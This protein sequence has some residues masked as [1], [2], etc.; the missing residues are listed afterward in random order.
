MTDVL[1]M[2]AGAVGG[3]FG[4]CLARA[5]HH[6]TFVARGANL[7]AIRSAGLRVTGAMGDFTIEGANATDKPSGRADLVV[8]CVKNYDLED[9]SRAVND[10]GG[11]VVTTQNGVDA[12]GVVASIVGDR[13]LA[14]TTGIV[15]DL[16]EPGHVHCVSAYAWLRF[17]E[18]HGGGISDRVRMV[19]DVLSVEGIEPLPVEDARVALWEK[20]A[21]MC[22]MAGLTTLHQQPMGYILSDP[23]LRTQF[24]DVVRE[25][26]ALAR[27]QGVALADDF[28]SKRIGYALGIDPAAMSSMSRDF[29]RGRQ[30][31]LETFNGAAVRL[32]ESLGVDVPVNRAIYEAIAAKR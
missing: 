18:P 17:G 5:G 20:M 15:A 1:V 12:P 21:L 28:S 6:V 19:T 32:G 13:V 27:A 26:E 24:E 23:A 29:A 7:E 16:P 2:G 4:A 10:V 14:G 22:G 9:A 31:E 30:I 25:C 8:M 3:Y 11:V